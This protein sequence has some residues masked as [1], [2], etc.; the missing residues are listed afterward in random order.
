MGRDSLEP[1][2][3][4]EGRG[5]FVLAKTSNAGSGLLQ[6]QIVDG[7]PV[8]E[9]VAREA[10]TWATDGNVGLVVGAT[11]PAQLRSIRKLAG[12]MPILVP[13]VGA[14]QG[15]LAAAVQAGLDS[16]GFGML[17]NA[18][19]AV[20]Y[21]SDGPDFAEAARSA[22]LRLRSEIEEAKAASLQT[23]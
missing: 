8:S 21:A 15:D 4:R 18:S 11:Y 9:R 6:D 3:S 19:R 23:A 13:G 14:Q 1:L 7:A 12:D 10:S 2:L 17:I 22:A 5:V 20:A 16:T